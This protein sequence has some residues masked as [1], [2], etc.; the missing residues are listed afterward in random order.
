[1]NSSDIV[2][3]FD[4]TLRDGEQSPGA[5]MK[6]QTKLEIA[7]GLQDLGVDVIEAGFPIAS[8]GDFEGVARIAE[9]VRGVTIAALARATVKDIDSARRALEHAASPRIHTFIGSSPTHRNKLH[10]NKQQVIDRACAAIELAKQSVNDVQFSPEDAGRTELD[11]LVQL[12]TE[13]IRAGA[14]TINIPDTVG[15]CTPEEYATIFTYLQNRVPGIDRVIVSAHTHD[16]LGMATAN[17][18]A[19]VQAGARQ[20]ECTINGIGERAGNAS[21]EEVVMALGT[22]PERFG[23]VTTGIQTQRL[24]AMS[25]MVQNATWKVPRNKAIVGQNAFSHEA[26]IHQDGMLKNRKTY[27]IMRPQDVGWEDS[28]LVLG[29]H[30]GTAAVRNHITELG[31]PWV[32]ADATSFMKAFTRYADALPDNKKYI[33]DACLRDDIYFP[34]IISRTN[35]GNPR[36][37]GIADYTQAASMA[38][39]D[40]NLPAHEL[41]SK[42]HVIITLSIG[43]SNSRVEFGESGKDGGELIDAAKVAMESD[44][45]GVEIHSY[46]NVMAE[47]AKG[48]HSDAIGTIVLKCGEFTAQ[49]IGVAGGVDASNLLAMQE[50]YNRLWAQ[51]EYVKMSG[52]TDATS[53]K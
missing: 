36:M 24:L 11:F 23:G 1:M 2:R 14:T 38:A 9:K 26:G 32:D 48:S 21:L 20:V 46:S 17:A 33:D 18:L 3:I 12:V 37:S 42:K 52:I 22:R 50:A 44:V 10:M 19:A 45:P 39:A 35:G 27:E 5:S 41:L 43:K 40:I 8:E 30:S 4:T 31:L 16:D 49:G 13:A 47:P 15:Y 6:P 51:I 7:H 29:K 34:F 25:L 53:E 28:S